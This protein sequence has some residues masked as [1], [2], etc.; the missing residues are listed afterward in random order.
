MQQKNAT[1]TR[2]SPPHDQAESSSIEGAILQP[3]GDKLFLIK[4]EQ[5]KNEEP[6]KEEDEKLTKKRANK[7]NET[8]YPII[9][10]NLI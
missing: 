10:F 8:T 1:N 2:S 4:E 9:K 5:A 6:D 7:P 3:Y